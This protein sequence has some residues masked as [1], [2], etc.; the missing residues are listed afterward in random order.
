MR[1]FVSRQS[2]GSGFTLLEILIAVAILGILA[3]VV[4]LAINPQKQLE[5]ARDAQ[6]RID[7]NTI[8]NAVYQFQID[9]SRLPQFDQE[10]AIPL[11]ES[12]RLEICELVDGFDCAVNPPKA[13]LYE[14]I[15]YGQLTA[16][17]QDPEDSDPRGTGYEIW[18]TA[19]GRLHVRAP[20]LRNGQG[21]TVEK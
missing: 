21:L 8:L 14:L 2:T 13:F 3:A 7:L 15:E 19:D 10:V 1:L 16:L 6:R 4:I 11:G 17:P 9:Q 18:R 5:D 20:R 12:E